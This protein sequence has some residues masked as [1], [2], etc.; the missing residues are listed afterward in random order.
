MMAYAPEPR[1]RFRTLIDERY[2]HAHQMSA[3]VALMLV[4]VRAEVSLGVL[5]SAYRGYRIAPDTALRL[6]EWAYLEHGCEDL[7]VEHLCTAPKRP[8]DVRRK[9][10]Q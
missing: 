6:K 5:W 10:P 8:R 4:S 9:G 7:D 2:V 1:T 3:S